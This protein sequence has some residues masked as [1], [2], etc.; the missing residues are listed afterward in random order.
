MRTKH[1]HERLLEAVLFNSRWLMAPFYVGLIG[2]LVLLLVV[3][4]RELFVALPKALSA[5]TD[6][7]IVTML[8]L[9]D[10][11]L[12]GNL[13]L[14]VIFSGYENFVSRMDSAGDDDDRP[15]WMGTVDF[16]GLKLKLVASIVAISAIDL[17]KAFLDIGTDGE[18]ALNATQLT[19]K[20]AVHLTFVGSGVLLALMDW[21]IVKSDPAARAAREKIGHEIEDA[22]PS[23]GSSPAAPANPGPATP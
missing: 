13:V 3:F 7:A 9:V 2:S 19:F 5:S 11:S 8:T 17:L 6:D 15:D 23:G 14:I 12:A 20:I 18:E 22:A 4:V 16:S 10:L 1:V 21:L